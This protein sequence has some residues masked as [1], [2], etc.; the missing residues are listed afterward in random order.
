MRSKSELQ[1]HIFRYDKINGLLMQSDIAQFDRKISDFRIRWPKSPEF[2][3]QSKKSEHSAHRIIKIKKTVSVINQV[4]IILSRAWYTQQGYEVHTA[5]R[6][7]IDALHYEHNH[8]ARTQSP[9]LSADIRQLSGDAGSI[10]ETT[11]SSPPSAPRAWLRITREYT[12]P[13]DQ[14]LKR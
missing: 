4:Q 12:H 7:A 8:D 9:R 1:I 13:S 11:K 14:T 5:V 2:G 3:P 10:V 6:V